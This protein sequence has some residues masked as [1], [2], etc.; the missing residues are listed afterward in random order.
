[1]AVSSGFSEYTVKT[2]VA[3]GQ[4]LG[5]VAVA[6]GTDA[7]VELL[8]DGDFSYALTPQEKTQIVLSG[9]GFVY[10]P[11]AKGQEAGYAYILLEGK[12]VG[13]VPLV[14]GRGVEQKTAEPQSFWERLFEGD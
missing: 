2:I 1:M 3:Q 12:P 10:A 11:I 4:R 6:G 8:A 5:S 14:Y 9:T 7:S 13:K